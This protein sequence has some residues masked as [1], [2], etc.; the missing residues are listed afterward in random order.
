M[1][2]AV[3]ILFQVQFKKLI[4]G[5][6][7]NYPYRYILLLL[8]LA[9]IGYS[10]GALNKLGINP[11]LTTAVSLSIVFIYLLFYFMM[12]IAFLIDKN[13]EIEFIFAMPIPTGAWFRAKTVLMSLMGITI[14][15][16]MAFG[17][18]LPFGEQ[19]I[20]AFLIVFQTGIAALSIA[21]LFVAGFL[22][23]GIN[24]DKAVEYGQIA[25]S[26]GI[27]AWFLFSDQLKDWLM[28]A[29]M[30]PSSLKALPFYPLA[31]ALLQNE[32]RAIVTYFVMILIFALMV[33]AFFQNS[34]VSATEMEKVWLEKTAEKEPSEPI[35][36]T[37][38]ALSFNGAT[39]MLV[40]THLRR[41]RWFRS[42]FLPPGILYLLLIAHNMANP[43][44]SSIGAVVG[45]TL[46]MGAL[47]TM[48]VFYSSSHK[49][50]WL[51]E[52]V[53]GRKGEITAKVLEW[54]LTLVLGA[55]LLLMNMVTLL[56]SPWMFRQILVTS[57]FSLLVSYG[58]AYTYALIFRTT[59]FSQD[60]TTSAS[61]R[62]IGALVAFP[63]VIIFSSAWYGLVKFA[64][65]WTIPALILAFLLDFVLRASL[66]RVKS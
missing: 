4:R 44:E 20:Q 17:Y 15:G 64:P 43:S 52:T 35:A 49:A 50:S 61:N 57:V 30:G 41:D 9:F 24:P 16:M 7:K 46:F 6:S 58:M 31:N 1:A 23:M 22:K 47:V 32:I 45:I 2:S 39:L 33:L 21:L 65:Q 48:S 8:L 51:I 62:R 27:G 34:L 60:Y 59:P 14:S 18:A 54:T 3:R 25:L 13:R 29:N 66:C 36:R 19:A 5:K 11:L 37:L 12:E 38:R 26:V 28:N 56:V 42:S 63:F 10:L 55:F 53:P 40:V